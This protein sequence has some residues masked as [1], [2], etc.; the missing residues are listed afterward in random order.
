M[1]DALFKYFLGLGFVVTVAVTLAN[2]AD[3]YYAANGT[4]DG[5]G[6]SIPSSISGVPEISSTGLTSLGLLLVG[7]LAVITSRCG[8]SPTA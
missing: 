7:G 6:W 8:S 2:Y 5:S 3:N 4:F 1:V